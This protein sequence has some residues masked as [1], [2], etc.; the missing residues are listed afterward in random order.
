M[1]I[2]SHNNKVQHQWQAIA[3]TAINEQILR[4]GCP[5]KSWPAFN[6]VSHESARYHWWL[7]CGWG[8]IAG[9]HQFLWQGNSSSIGCIDRVTGVEAVQLTSKEGDCGNYIWE[10]GGRQV[11][12]C[13]FGSNDNLLGGAIGWYCCRYRRDQFVQL[14]CLLRISYSR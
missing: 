1:H 6:A 11:S 5:V 14:S 8:H 13:E 9:G 10:L 2:R 12:I 3:Q 7:W 4:L